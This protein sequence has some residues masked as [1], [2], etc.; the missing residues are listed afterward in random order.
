LDAAVAT[1]LINSRIVWG[2]IFGVFLF[3][4]RIGTAQA[5]GTATAIVGVTLVLSGDFRGGEPLAMI[6]VLIA[7]IF[8]VLMAATVKR[9]VPRDDVPLALLARFVGPT[10]L[11]TV[12]SFS[13]DPD[14]SFLSGRAALMLAVGALI[15]PFL[16]F[17]FVFTAMP[18]VRLGV[19]VL[20]Q[21]LPIV[22]TSVFSFLVF[23]TIPTMLQCMGGALILVSVFVVGMNG[24]RDAA[25]VPPLFLRDQRKEHR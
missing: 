8:Y 5:I 4:E 21:S 19:Q 3:G 6:S 12:V 1:F 16:S 7:A 15:G 22:F 9:H 18:L 25:G 23:G 14:V 11:L 17:L 24:S 13:L 2:A 10:V 20:F